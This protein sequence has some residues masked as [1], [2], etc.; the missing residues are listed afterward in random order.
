MGL[1]WAIPLK[2]PLRLSLLGAFIQALV[3][4]I[5]LELKL[6]CARVRAVLGWA[7]SKEVP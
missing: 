2:G 3:H 5:P 7:S 6:K 4:L 1:Y